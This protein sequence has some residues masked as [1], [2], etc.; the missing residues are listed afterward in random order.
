MELSSTGR[1]RLILLLAQQ[2][3]SICLYT[4]GDKL[5]RRS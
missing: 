4:A 3:L 2:I 5:E 1:E